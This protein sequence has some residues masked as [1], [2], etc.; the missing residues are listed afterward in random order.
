[1]GGTSEVVSHLAI[2]SGLLEDPIDGSTPMAGFVESLRPLHPAEERFAHSSRESRLVVP[3][4]LVAL[5][6]VWRE[7][8]AGS[9]EVCKGRV[10]Q[11]PFTPRPLAERTSAGSWPFLPGGVV[12]VTAGAPPAVTHGVNGPAGARRDRHCPMP[13][14]E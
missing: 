8:P 4:P 1:M 14:R 9:A 12:Q 3:E 10:D 6:G 5:P 11:L 2:T 13:L 7:V